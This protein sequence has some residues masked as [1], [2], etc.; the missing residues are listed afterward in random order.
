MKIGLNA[1]SK[2]D[3]SVSLGKISMMRKL[4]EYQGVCIG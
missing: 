2:K 3:G 4:I 1:L